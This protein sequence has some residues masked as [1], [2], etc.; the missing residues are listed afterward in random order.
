MACGFLRLTHGDECEAAGAA[1]H[2]IHHQVGFN[3][4]AMG[5][6]R[7][8]EIVFGGVEGKI[9][10]KQFVIHVMIYCPRLTPAFQTVPD[11]R[12]SNHH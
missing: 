8:L 12:V 1:G 7:V 3:D 9:S 11:C 6:K 10:Y 2:A 5:G 4:R